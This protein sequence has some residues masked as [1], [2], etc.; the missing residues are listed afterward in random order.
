MPDT[1]RIDPQRL[2]DTLAAINAF[3]HDPATGGYNRTGF[4]ADDMAARSRV[5]GMMAEA[6]LDVRT[7]AVGNTFGR[8]G[9]AEGP[10]ILIGSHT[11]TV[12]Q[13]GAYDGAL[14]VAVGLEC[15]RGIAD[16]GVAL[17]RAVEV[18]NTVDEEGRFGGM[19]G[20]QAMAGL[21]G[22]AWVAQ[23]RDAQGTPL[24]EAMRAHGLDPAATDAAALPPGYASAF[25]ELHIEQGPVL[26][27]AGLP[28][29]VVTTVSGCCVLQITLTGTANHSGTTPMEL[30]AD[31]FAGLAQA[32][33]AIPDIVAS[34][35]TD[36]SRLTIGHVAL[37]PDEPHTIPGRAEFS[38]VL[39]DT[40]E[41]VMRR[42]RDGFATALEAAVRD[43]DLALDIVERSWLPPVDLDPELRATMTR[44][45]EAAGRPAMEMPS[46]AGHDAQTMQAACPAALIFVPS[47]GGISHAPAEHSDWA[48][49]VAGAEVMLAA[50]ADL[51]TRPG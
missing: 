45:A 37:A 21:A 14:G 5:A 11:D 30:R 17:T 46:G 18:V 10:A 25:L 50:L 41:G 31:A 6:G 8:L 16:A 2:W 32:A 24:A 27:R 1:P 40:D 34:R 43:H 7:D 49:C 15:A 22:A 33:A 28:V 9:P 42:L 26:E 3:G 39:R 48:D 29:G 13:G 19:L 38:L 20:S 35:G 36:Q 44:A 12:P 47:R 23:A 4:T 51:A